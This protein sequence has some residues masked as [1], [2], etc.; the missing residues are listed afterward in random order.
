[1]AEGRDSSTESTVVLVFIKP[2]SGVWVCFAELIV[3]L[4]E[5][6]RWILCSQRHVNCLAKGGLSSACASHLRRDCQEQNLCQAQGMG[7]GEGN[8]S[9][10]LH[11]VWCLFS[12]G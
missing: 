7:V 1:M 2:R 5:W 4:N 8:G 12:S 6:A 11:T 3:L 9:E 10:N